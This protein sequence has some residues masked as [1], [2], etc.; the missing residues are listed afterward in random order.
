MGLATGPLRMSIAS[1]AIA[2][3]HEFQVQHIANTPWAM[4][5]LSCMH[6]P[7]R[8]AIAASALRLLSESQPGCLARP[9]WAWAAWGFEVQTG[10]EHIHGYWPAHN[11]PCSQVAAN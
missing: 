8:D 7:L 2:R 6:E 4:A 11:A 10:M 9:A 5:V 1:S 3:L